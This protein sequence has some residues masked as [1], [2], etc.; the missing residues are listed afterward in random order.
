MLQCILRNTFSFLT[1]TS[2]SKSFLKA[3]V[4]HDRDHRT[5]PSKTPFFQVGLESAVTVSLHVSVDMTMR[6]QLNTH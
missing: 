2:C 4:C 3:F 6:G 1:A 5:R